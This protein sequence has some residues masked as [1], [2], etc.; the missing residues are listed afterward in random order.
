[1]TLPDFYLLGSRLLLR[2]A[3]FTYM[4]NNSALLTCCSPQRCPYSSSLSI[5]RAWEAARRLW[6]NYRDG[7]S[8]EKET[9]PKLKL[10]EGPSPHP[11]PAPLTHQCCLHPSDF[12][13]AG[14]P[15]GAP[16]APE[17]RGAGHCP[18]SSMSHTEHPLVHG[19]SRWTEPRPEEPLMKSF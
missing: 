6:D 11:V 13:Q 12:I 14:H 5:F 17:E 18:R 3:L 15:G 9:G 4:R 1:M 2:L 16:N 10:H 19:W 7:K 8:K